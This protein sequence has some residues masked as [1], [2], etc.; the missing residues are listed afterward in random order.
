MNGSRAGEF[1]GWAVDLSGVP[2]LNY[3]A[4]KCAE[5]RFVSA[6]SPISAG[7]FDG[8]TWIRC[9]GKGSF[10]SSPALKR[11]GE[12]RVG[13]GDDLLVVDLE[14]CTG[15]DSTF[16]GTLAGLAMKLAKAG[17]GVLQVTGMDERN[18]RSLEDLGLDY[19]LQIEPEDAP[20]RGRVGH[21]RSLLVP[22]NGD[23]QGMTTEQRAGHVLEAHRLLS[24]ANDGNEER[25]RGVIDVLEAEIDGRK[26]GGEAGRRAF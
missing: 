22:V 4:S 10:R 13:E 26:R 16:M 17:G 8:F 7:V 19:V 15:M 25:F 23:E 18:R 5:A 12:A 3:A 2:G 20:W 6:S 11:F 9:E 1:H 14:G 21:L 24:A